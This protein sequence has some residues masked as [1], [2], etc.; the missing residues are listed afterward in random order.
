MMLVVALKLSLVTIQRLAASRLQ[1]LHCR[2]KK[3]HFLPWQ[4]DD[5]MDGVLYARL[6]VIPCVVATLKAKS[7][8]SQKSRTCGR[9]PRRIYMHMAGV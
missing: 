8:V 3:V 9:Q 6:G 5:V 4:H 7:A 1:F 2:Q